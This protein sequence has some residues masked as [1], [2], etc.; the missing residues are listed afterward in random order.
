MKGQAGTHRHL[1]TVHRHPAWPCH[2]RPGRWHGHVWWRHPDHDAPIYVKLHAD[3]SQ[4]TAEARAI[5]AHLH[6]IVAERNERRD[7]DA[8][9][10][11]DF[12]W[13]LWLADQYREAM[14]SVERICLEARA[15]V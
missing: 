5:Q 13:R 2:P 10:L 8:R 4:Y 6:R 7:R 14:D 12:E 3:S 1:F 15:A 9:E 11:A